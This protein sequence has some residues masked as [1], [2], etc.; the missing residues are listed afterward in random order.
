M[1]GAA[2]R[3][4]T[5]MAHSGLPGGSTPDIRLVVSDMDG[6]LLDDDGRVPDGFW[7]LL[8][9]M[10]SRGV[11]FVPASGRQ[12]QSLARLF[13]GVPGLSY[14]GDNGAVTVHGGEMFAAGAM[15]PAF[16][17][18]AIETMRAANRDGARL[19]AVVSRPS[20]AS[21]ESGDQD[22]AVHARTYCAALDQVDDLTGVVDEVVKI[23]IY[24]F[25]DASTTVAGPLAALGADHKLVVSGRNW[26]DITAP[27]VHKA[28]GVR[29]LQSLLGVTPAQTVV[30]GDY[31]NDVE[32]LDAA[33]WSFAM[34]NAHPA[35]AA[36]ARY[37]APSNSD[38][39]VVTVLRELLG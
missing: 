18:H 5:G 14:V 28:L 39:G 1:A 26:I 12:Y 38:H 15:D 20:G 25:D 31:L 22:F 24:D 29:R 34:A 23:A 6:T 30:F 3:A 11:A 7:P 32:M 17:V 35:V 4:L 19:R 21:I 36:R 9:E 13:D 37:R 27:S 16:V 33:D 8:D 2:G 10:R